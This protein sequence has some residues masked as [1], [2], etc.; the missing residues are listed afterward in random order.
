MKEKNKSLNQKV[1]ELQSTISSILQ[2]TITKEEMK[3]MIKEGLT[4][5]NNIEWGKEKETVNTEK[6]AEN[7]DNIITS[8]NLYKQTKEQHLKWITSILELLDGRLAVG[9]GGGAISLNQMN[10][11]I[12]E[13]TVLTQRD[14]A[15]DAQITSLC[16]LS[17]K[18]IVSSSL[19]KTIKVWNVLSDK[20]IQ[21]ITTLT[22][23]KGEVDKVIAL[24]H[25]RFASY[26]NDDGTVKLYNSETYEQIQIPFE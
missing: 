16:E 22:Q 7:K 10:Y 13:W 9:C 25:N 1:E 12:K 18:R 5:I 6:H 26:S 4:P 21:L 14:K 3:E 24:T 17:N 19:D 8:I 23:H 2:R 20:D 11:E 15:H